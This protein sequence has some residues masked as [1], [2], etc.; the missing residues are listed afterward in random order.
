MP[1]GG[2][3]SLSPTVEQKKPDPKIHTHYMILSFQAV[4]NQPCG[5]CRDVVTFWVGCGAVAVGWGRFLGAGSA[6]CSSEE[7][8]HR[9][10]QKYT[11]AVHAR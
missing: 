2:G 7:W 5:T 3:D 1:H 6:P 9:I 11:Q 8:L 4:E 10:T